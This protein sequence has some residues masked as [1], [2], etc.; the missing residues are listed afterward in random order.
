MWPLWSRILGSIALISAIPPVWPYGYYTLLRVGICL[1]CATLAY[2][3]N[4]L[5][6]KNWMVTFTI[7][8]VI[9]NPLL[10]L[11]L[12]KELWALVDLVSAI[13]LLVSFKQLKTEAI[14]RAC[15]QA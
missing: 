6:T 3:A 10:P 2:V 9:F 11:H 15:N 14:V 7:I 8:A 12:G 4:H 13:V 5:K 1:L